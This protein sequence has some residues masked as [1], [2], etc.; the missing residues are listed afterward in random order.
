MRKL[1]QLVFGDLRNV[2]S[3]AVA[4]LVALGVSRLAPGAAGAALA[5]LLIV[6]AALQAI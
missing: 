4:L 1:L 6:A 3:V 2:A 5:L